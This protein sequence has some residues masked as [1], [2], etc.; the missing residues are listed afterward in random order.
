MMVNVTQLRAPL[1]GGDDNV[2]P[3][4]ELL[5]RSNA[6]AGTA[7]TLPHR[8]DAHVHLLLPRMCQSWCKG[9]APVGWLKCN[10]SLSAPTSQETA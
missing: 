6:G 5:C 2:G 3:R 8:Q 9:A 1:S 4:V 10:L 7:P